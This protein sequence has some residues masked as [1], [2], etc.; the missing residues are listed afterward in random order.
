MEKQY[1]PFGL[2]TAG[3]SSKA[4][5]SL[6]N[7]Y[8]FNG[9]E[10]QCNEF[11]DGSGLET[12]DFG[13]RH[14]DPQLGRWFVI[15][16]MADAMRRYSPYNYAFDNPIRYI[17]PDGMM[18]SG[19]KGETQHQYGVFGTQMGYVQ[20]DEIEGGMGIDGIYVDK[21]G[22][23]LGQDANKDD[24]TVRV[25]EKSDWDKVEKDKEGNVIKQGTSTV[26]SQSTELVGT[27][28]EQPGYQKGINIS[29]KTWDK[30]E[31]LGGERAI[32]FLE[33]KSGGDAYIKPENDGVGY[34]PGGSTK[35]IDDSRQRV[36]PG[37]SVYGLVDG[38]KTSKYS[39]AIFKLTTGTKATVN[40]GGEVSYSIL[41]SPGTFFIGGWTTNL[42]NSNF[43]NLYKA[44][45]GRKPY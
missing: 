34:G 32:P 10:Q 28:K 12:Y 8:R 2:T 37:E 13:A 33:N 36:K 9:K 6:T 20:G 27:S 29:D 11:S 23:Y 31:S 7:K 21:D 42:S 16:P 24:K 38:I 26:E 5:G 17:D 45:V 15:D 35:V 22:N 41:Q 1:Y 14:Y 43:S 39:D 25:I 3:I 44:P 4:A 30:I 19:T 40:A 18:P